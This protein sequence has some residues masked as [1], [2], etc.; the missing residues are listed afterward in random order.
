V[1]STVVAPE[2]TRTLPAAVRVK[3]SSKESGRSWL[4]SRLWGRMEIEYAILEI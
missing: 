2:R 3:P 1:Q 4:G